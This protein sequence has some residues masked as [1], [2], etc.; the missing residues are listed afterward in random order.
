MDLNAI[1]SGLC[2]QIKRAILPIFFDSSWFTD[3]PIRYKPTFIVNIT[4]D[5]PMSFLKLDERWNQELIHNLART[6]LIS[7]ILEI[8]CNVDPK[9]DI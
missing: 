3:L 8:I 2:K 5:F 7:S 6:N 9:D 4:D 1:K